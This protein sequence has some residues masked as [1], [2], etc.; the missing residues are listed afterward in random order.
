MPTRWWKRSVLCVVAFAASVAVVGT[1]L[2]TW[3]QPTTDRWA[4]IVPGD[5]LDKVLSEL[6]HPLRQYTAASGPHDYYV[7][8]YGRKERPISHRVL[9]YMAKDMILYVWIDVNERVEE[10]FVGVS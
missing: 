8:G 7:S 4:K 1:M 6:G 9:I 5:P 3:R 10:V 2:E